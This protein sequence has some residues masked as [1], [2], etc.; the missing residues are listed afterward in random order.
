MTSTHKEMIQKYFYEGEDDKGMKKS[1][2]LMVEA[3][4]KELD[5]G[6]SHSNKKH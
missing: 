2:A 1:A 4:I 6:G 5:S 3:M